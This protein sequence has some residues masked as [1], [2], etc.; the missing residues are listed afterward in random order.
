MVKLKGGSGKG[1][2][3]SERCQEIEGSDMKK[4]VKWK[5]RILTKGLMKRVS[6]ESGG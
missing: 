3:G 1:E 5:E 4:R 2:N 6:M